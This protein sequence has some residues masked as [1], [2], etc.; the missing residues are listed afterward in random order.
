MRY[1]IVLI[2]LILASCSTDLIYLK[3]KDT[4]QIATCG[5]HFVGLEKDFKMEGIAMQESQC[6]QD[7][8]E[9]GFIRIPKPQ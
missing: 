4:G 6:I 1:R 5:G 3:N 7:Y 9:Q 8:K 2:P